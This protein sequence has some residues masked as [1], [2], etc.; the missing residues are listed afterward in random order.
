MSLLTNKL[1]L[2]SPGSRVRLTHV[3]GQIIEGVVA[4]NDGKESLSVQITSLATLRYDQITLLDESGL[5]GTVYPVSPAALSLP[6]SNEADQPS[7]FA[8]MQVACDKDV[9]SQAFKAMEPEEKKILTQAYDKFQSF[10]QSHEDEKC[11]EAVRLTWKRIHENE[12]Y[13][14]PGVN[15]FYGLLQLAHG[16]Y[17]AAAESFYYS[18][19][20]RY[21]YCTAYQGTGSDEKELHQL[22]AAFA[23]IYLISDQASEFMEAANRFAYISL[24]SGLSIL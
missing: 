4:E 12:W 20:I 9:V 14:N 16:E 13:Y 19:N 8:V 7:G 1:S 11:Q 2:L 23:A 22:A 5:S 15:L 24:K 10:L 17:A 6:A 3:S 18:E 21:A